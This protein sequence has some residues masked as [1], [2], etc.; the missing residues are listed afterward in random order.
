MAQVSGNAQFQLLDFTRISPAATLHDRLPAIHQDRQQ[1]KRRNTMLSRE[2]HNMKPVVSQLQGS[3]LGSSR[4]CSVSKL[5]MEHTYCSY[6]AL[7]K[8]GLTRTVAVVVPGYP[9][10]V[11]IARTSDLVA[12]VPRLCLGKAKAAH[13][14]AAAGLQNFPLPIQ[15][16]EILVSAIWHPRMDADPAHR[17]LRHLVIGFCKKAYP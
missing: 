13:D 2:D 16:P 1:T 11:R 15:L 6:N 7:E 14:A 9:D 17:W 10:A 12:S 5:S 4:T 3:C 8:L